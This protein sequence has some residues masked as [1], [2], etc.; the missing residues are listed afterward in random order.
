VLLP[1]ADYRGRAANLV[2]VHLHVHTWSVT[3]A[4]PAES[5]RLRLARPAVF[6]AFDG[7]ASLIGVVV[8]LAAAHPS[9]IF[10]AAVSG[11]LTSA[12][13]M[14]GGEFLSDS[15]SGWAASAVMA[16]ATF[17]GALA[18]AVPFAFGH[19]AA[20]TAGCAVICAVVIVI[21]A[22]LRLNRGR[23][24]ALAETAGLFAAAVIVALACARLLPGGTA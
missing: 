14:G 7:A 5:P 11:A 1:C 23:G 2:H 22:A 21:V 9:L 24:L 8:Y 17:T 6:G 15:D 19:G 3:S 4:R 18:P 16:A 12:V 13:S 20:V 10:P